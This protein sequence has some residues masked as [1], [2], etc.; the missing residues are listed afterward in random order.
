MELIERRMASRY[1]VNLL[2]DVGLSNE[3]Q[4]RLSVCNISAT[5]MRIITSI[6]NL[7]FLFPNQQRENI[8]DTIHLNVAVYLPEPFVKADV[9]VGAVYTQRLSHQQF[10]VGCRFERFLQNSASV[11]AD[12][13]FSIA[14]D[15]FQRNQVIRIS[16]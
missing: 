1:D 9:I 11:L 3:E 12:Y 7:V 13:L 10:S 2:A 5:G 8:I 14:N 6:E 4:L 15:D 16:Q